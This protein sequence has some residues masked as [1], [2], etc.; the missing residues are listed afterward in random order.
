ML[1]SS[2]SPSIHDTSFEVQCQWSSQT[3]RNADCV[4]VLSFP[5]R[6]ILFWE[7]RGKRTHEYPDTRAQDIKLTTW[8]SVFGCN[9]KQSL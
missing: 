5:I 6:I 3:T 8:Y 4:L 7:P 9:I 1:S 2:P